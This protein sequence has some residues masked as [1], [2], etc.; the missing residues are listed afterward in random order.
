[1]LFG[2]QPPD[3][4]APRRSLYLYDLHS[5]NPRHAPTP[6]LQICH[7]LNT[8]E[9]VHIGKLPHLLNVHGLDDLLIVEEDPRGRLRQLLANERNVVPILC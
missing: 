4:C 8:L 5:P 7:S 1:M 6:M 3:F 9:K 2:L